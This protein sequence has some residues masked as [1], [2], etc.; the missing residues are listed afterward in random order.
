[1][2][3]FEH[4][5]E[6]VIDLQHFGSTPGIFSEQELKERALAKFNDMQRDF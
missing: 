1:M 4:Q 3:S 6:Y 2:F 5:D